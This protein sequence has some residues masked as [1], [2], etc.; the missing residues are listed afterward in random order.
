MTAATA[1]KPPLEA[2]LNVRGPAS[3]NCRCAPLK[4]TWPFP[5]GPP[6]ASYAGKVADPLA[7]LSSVEI[8]EN[9]G[10]LPETRTRKLAHISAPPDIWHRLDP[11]EEDEPRD[12][13]VA[14]LQQSPLPFGS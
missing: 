1:T 10:L 4:L 3:K 2:I 11:S 9:L 13:V 7:A 12:T 14:R 5:C 6:R 8:D